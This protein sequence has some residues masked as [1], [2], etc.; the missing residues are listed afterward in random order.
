MT[1]H[2]SSSSKTHDVTCP[3]CSTRLTVLTADT[4][5]KME[6]PDCGH[7]LTITKPEQKVVLPSE[8]EDI[9]DIYGLKDVDDSHDEARKKLGQNL[10]SQAEK[11]IR[12]QAERPELHK[13]TQGA[14]EERRRVEAI[15]DD[16]PS[17]PREPL[18]PID[19]DPRSKL[20]EF[21]IRFT[22]QELS[23]DVGLF[24][25]VG[26]LMR[27][28]F[29]SLFTAMVLYLV[30]NAVYY[31]NVTP[32]TFMSYMA[33]MA[34][35][36]LSV[37]LG[38]VAV[39]FLGSYFLFLTMSISSGMDDFDWPELGIFDRVMEA[40]F[41]VA[42]L[43]FALI[44]F[45]VVA[46]IDLTLALPLLALGFLAFPVAFLSLLDQNSIITPWSNT[47]VF[48]LF[49]LTGKWL[50]FYVATFFLTIAVGGFGYMLY[51]FAGIERLAYIALPCGVLVVGGLMIYSIWLGR[52]SWEI[53]ALHGEEREAER[54]AKEAAK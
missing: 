8:E 26:L 41:F 28:V 54:E 1:E 51:F 18:T 6:C 4:G 10:M 11:E 2:S 32:P 50:M 19:Y 7:I 38:T 3:V 48:S 49:K 35:T 29:L 23:R 22:P 44:P 43:F 15:D 40:L 31:S 45:A 20:V 14:F 30:I 42:G 47:V 17:K 25:D 34:C 12:E 9:E 36:F 13:R 46:T 5:R 53:S 52:M 33:S 16:V 37:C 24:T 39:V 27:W 21:P